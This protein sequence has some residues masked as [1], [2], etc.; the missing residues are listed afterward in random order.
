VKRVTNS[1]ITGDT[2]SIELR[3][4]QVDIQVSSIK[5]IIAARLPCNAAIGGTKYSAVVGG[6]NNSILTSS[7]SDLGAKVF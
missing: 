6:I 7:L 5:N 4:Y 2:G 3:G 1:V